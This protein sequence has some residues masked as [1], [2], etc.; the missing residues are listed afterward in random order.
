MGLAFFFTLGIMIIMSVAGA[1]INPKAFN[2]DTSMFR[3]KPVTLIQIII[4]LMILM[5]LYVKFW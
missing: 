5:A 2:N 4:I 3:V 1:K